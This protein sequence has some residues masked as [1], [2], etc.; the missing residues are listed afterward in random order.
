MLNTQSHIIH[1]LKYD[2]HF[3]NAEANRQEQ[4]LSKLH[5]EYLKG[6]LEELLDKYAPDGKHLVGDMIEI[7]LGSIPTDN[8]L[9]TIKT[10]MNI[11]F[12]EKFA[13]PG[14]AKQ[15]NEDWLDTDTIHD[16]AGSLKVISSPQHKVM[17][18]LHFLSKGYFG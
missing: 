6:F 1:T 10:R 5:Y 12:E 9:E 2:I 16:K 3:Q 11:V 7:D 13:N 17:A 14:D 4:S 8:M 18:L 15:I